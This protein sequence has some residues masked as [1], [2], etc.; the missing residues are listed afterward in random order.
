MNSNKQLTVA[1]VLVFV[2]TLLGIDFARSPLQKK[3]SRWTGIEFPQ[4]QP[5][6]LNFKIV[7]DFPRESPR[8]PQGDEPDIG[9][10]KGDGVTP[11]ASARITR[12][13]ASTKIEF[14]VRSFP[15][16]AMYYLYVVDSSGSVIN[17]WRFKTTASGN[18]TLPQ[19][20]TTDAGTFMLALSA[21][22]KL[23]DIETD[24]R[25]LMISLAPS[26]FPI[27]PKYY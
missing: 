17:R 22:Y 3:K 20:L 4:G 1:V 11:T 12:V 19:G 27:A 7:G 26:G 23:T 6:N 16:N 14:S 5:V 24:T 8:P 21:A 13:G 18:A 10:E 2:M 25:V 15:K 9:T